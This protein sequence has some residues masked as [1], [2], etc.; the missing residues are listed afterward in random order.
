LHGALRWMAAGSCAAFG[1]HS[2]PSQVALHRRGQCRICPFGPCAVRLRA[3]AGL[4][5]H[6]PERFCGSTTH[7]PLY[8]S[9]LACRLRAAPLRLSHRACRGCGRAGRWGSP[10]AYCTI[11]R[12][13][14]GASKAGG[15][16]RSAQPA[17]CTRACGVAA[18]VVGELSVGSRSCPQSIGC[19]PFSRALAGFRR[20]RLG[21]T[22]GRRER[23]A[24]GCVRG[25]TQVTRRSGERDHCP[26][27]HVSSYRLRPHRDTERRG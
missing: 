18:P 10:L 15:F 24:C 26:W 19:A 14:E 2:S 13:H 1:Q 21:S 11:R 17:R 7:R 20:L 6:G 8:G 4:P 5:P 12:T 27:R 23:R 22:R 9:S 25:G 16:M 3:A